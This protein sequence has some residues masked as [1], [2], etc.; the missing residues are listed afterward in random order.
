MLVDRTRIGVA[1]ALA[2][3]TGFA[4]IAAAQ[5]AS[6]TIE[7]PI[8]SPG[9]AFIASTTFDLASVGYEQ[10]EYFISGTATAY[11]NT[12]PLGTDGMWSVAPSG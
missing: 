1:I 6:P 4:G 8:T 5:V 9:G 11:T 7:G 3:M 12:A 10:A 2:V